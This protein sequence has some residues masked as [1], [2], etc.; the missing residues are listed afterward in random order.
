LK[1][2]SR[3]GR[4][5]KRPCAGKVIVVQRISRGEAPARL[6][7]HGEVVSH[8][9]MPALGHGQRNRNGDRAGNQA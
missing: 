7:E 2:E 5:L 4:V 8:V 9:L 1:Q 3:E 6:P